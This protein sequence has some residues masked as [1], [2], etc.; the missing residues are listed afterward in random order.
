M[1]I[2][3][4]VSELQRIESQIAPWHFYLVRS[5]FGA[6]QEL[7]TLPQAAKNQNTS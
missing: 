3:Y 1:C 2:N 5:S 7:F 4:D 6:A